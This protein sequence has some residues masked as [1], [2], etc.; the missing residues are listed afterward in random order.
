M[1]LGI[2]MSSGIAFLPKVFLWIKS[3]TDEGQTRASMYHQSQRQA[4]FSFCCHTFS[5]PPSLPPFIPHSTQQIQKLCHHSNSCHLRKLPKSLLFLPLCVPSDIRWKLFCCGT[6]QLKRVWKKE[7]REQEKGRCG[8][9]NNK[10]AE[11]REER[12]WK[13]LM[14]VRK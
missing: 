12:R 10:A 8:G 11:W 3:N 13:S 9:N 1:V 5:L 7:G 4:P 14:M 6:T 2:S